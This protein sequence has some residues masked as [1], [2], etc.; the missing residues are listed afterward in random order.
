MPEAVE[1]I[2]NQWSLSVQVSLLLV[3]FSLFSWLDW[4]LKRLF[5]R[6]WRMA[7]AMNAL[8]LLSVLL[9][10]NWPESGGETGQRF[11]YQL[12][13]VFKLAF[14]V[15]L[16]RAL[17]ELK[18]HNVSFILSSKLQIGL[19]LMMHLAWFL[20]GFDTLQTQVM[21][22]LG[23]STILIIHCLL[24]FSESKKQRF[25]VI[26][27][28][29]L[30]EG[31]LFLHHGLVLIPALLGGSV[32]DYMTHISFIDAIYECVVGISCLAMVAKLMGRELQEANDLLADS[33]KQINHLM[34]RDYLTGMWHKN[35]FP[36]FMKLQT[37][38]AMLVTFEFINVDEIMRDWGKQVRD[39]CLKKMASVLK[40]NSDVTDGLFRI[41]A[42]QFLLVCPQ[43]SE[44][45]AESKAMNIAKALASDTQCGPIV[46]SKYVVSPYKEKG[47]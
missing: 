32:P 31:L 3:F 9:V 38:G 1:V 24:L 40:N 5:I 36:E 29:F 39:M 13:A 25:M 46:N 27:A 20:L 11:I 14:V 37:K 44:S 18:A 41:S 47:L 17:F 16:V 12:Y 35:Y 22:Y 8:A 26:W 34:N 21:V 28:V 7:W 42:S 19:Y 6:T 30:V 45:V 43:A 10:L 15:F 2:L 23:V 33:H 4:R